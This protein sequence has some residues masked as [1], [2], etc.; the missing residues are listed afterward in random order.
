MGIM[1]VSV[2]GSECG[3]GG[4]EMVICSLECFEVY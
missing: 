2:C 4:R 1:E 3:E